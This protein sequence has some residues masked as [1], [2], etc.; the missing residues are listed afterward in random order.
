VYITNY[1]IF[2]K[3]FSMIS[4]ICLCYNHARYIREALESVFKQ[5]Y[6]NWELYVVDDASTDNSVEVIQAF[7]AEKQGCSQTIRFIQN[8]ENQGNCK[9]F[10]LAYRQTVG[11]YIIDLAGDDV[12]LPTRLESQ[13]RLLDSLPAHYGVV[14]SNAYH[15]NEKG[16]ILHPHHTEGEQVPTGDIYAS[17]FQ[18][19][20][21]CTPTMLVRRQVLEDLGGYDETLSYEDFDFWVRSARTYWYYYQPEITTLKRKVQGSLSTK[22]YQAK[23]N[24][25]LA[26]TLK[27]LE[28]ALLLN[29]TH[30]EHEA[31]Q[32]CVGYHLRQAFFMQDYGLTTQYDTFW[33][34]IPHAKFPFWLRIVRVLNKWRVP[35][36]GL[37]KWYLRLKR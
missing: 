27:I 26:S 32:V 4:I 24:P 35:V 3:D 29:Q 30:T 36:S 20:F 31:L 33:R 19:Y 15:I 6:T 28:K 37:Y 9:S 34:N 11:K 16:A 17:L 14:F 5:T 22:F 8:T 10:N 1:F 12:F 13:A 7:L 25:H 18:K 2:F 23:H 21:I